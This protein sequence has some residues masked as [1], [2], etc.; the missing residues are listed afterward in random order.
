MECANGSATSHSVWPAPTH[1]RACRFTLRASLNTPHHLT[2]FNCPV[3]PGGTVVASNFPLQPLAVPDRLH[4]PIATEVLVVMPDTNVPLMPRTSL[5]FPWL[6]GLRDGRTSARGRRLH[7]RCP[8]SRQPGHDL[9]AGGLPSG[10][11]LRQPDRRR[12]EPG[13]AKR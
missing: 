2:V 3:A 6:A 11:R 1:P 9:D 5:T 10:D 7:R 12:V 8:A 13:R 4:P